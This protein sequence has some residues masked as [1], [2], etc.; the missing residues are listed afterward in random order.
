MNVLLKYRDTNWNKILQLKLSCLFVLIY[1]AATNCKNTY[2]SMN[3][4]EILLEIDTVYKFVKGS[5][6]I[7]P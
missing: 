5:G 1:S 2:C 7:S 6:G 3:F 4:Q